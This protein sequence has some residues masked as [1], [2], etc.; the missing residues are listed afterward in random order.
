MRAAVWHAVVQVSLPGD[1]QQGMRPA[2]RQPRMSVSEAPPLGSSAEGVS[3]VLMG[4]QCYSNAVAINSQP[5]L[6]ASLCGLLPPLCNAWHTMHLRQ[7]RCVAATLV[8]QP[9]RPVTPRTSNTALG[10]GG[11]G[12]PASGALTLPPAKGAMPQSLG[13]GSGGGGGGNAP[14]S[15][16]VGLSPGP[17][18]P[19]R[20][21][22]PMAAR[23]GSMPGSNSGLG[24]PLV[25]VRLRKLEM[26]RN[27]CLIW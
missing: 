8:L 10:S 2:T 5:M 19:V 3:G 23:R 1:R 21:Q 4:S 12:S 15:P 6:R 24:S 11:G 22:S 16:A 17:L 9:L 27:G 25:G 18:G 20:A 13:Q 7:Y 14:N 26:G